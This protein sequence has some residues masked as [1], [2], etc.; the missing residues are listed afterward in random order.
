[1]PRAK[2]K[3]KQIGRFLS[4]VAWIGGIPVLGEEPGMKL[5][6]CSRRWIVTRYV[7]RRLTYWRVPEIA[8]TLRIGRWEFQHLP[9]AL[10][11][12]PKGVTK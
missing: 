11:R 10:W 2:P 9:T 3:I 8:T 4:P 6:W 5:Y 12:E 7:R 1:M